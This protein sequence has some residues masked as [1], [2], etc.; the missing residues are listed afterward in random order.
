MYIC[1]CVYAKELS[2]RIRGNHPPPHV[3]YTSSR[4]IPDKRFPHAT[5]GMNERRESFG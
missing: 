1:I 3:N 2:A 4:T 5:M